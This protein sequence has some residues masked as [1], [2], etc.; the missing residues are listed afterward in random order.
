MNKLMLALSL[1]S[2]SFIMALILSCGEHND[3]S[4]ED[5]GGDDWYTKNPSAA[6]FT[7][8]TARQLAEFAELVNGDD[9]QKYGHP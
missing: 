9:D 4:S 3:S 2:V 5:T 8:R 1:I 6:E 7:I